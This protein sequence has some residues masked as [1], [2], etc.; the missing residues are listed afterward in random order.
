MTRGY[1]LTSGIHNDIEICKTFFI[2]KNQMSKIQIND[3][4]DLNVEQ[5]ATLTDLEAA[6]IQG[7]LTSGE[8]LAGLTLV[9]GAGAAAGA[10]AFAAPAV[11]AGVI[12]IAGISIVKSLYNAE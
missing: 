2:E 5:F 9:L 3:L 4:D 11:L 6:G 8:G 7:G 1:F 12:G 10:A